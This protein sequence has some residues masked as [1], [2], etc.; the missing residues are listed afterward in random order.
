MP[1]ESLHKKKEG[2]EG[3]MGGKLK[4]IITNCLQDV[5]QTI[6]NW[7]KSFFVRKENF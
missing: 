1:S 4:G 5:A 3:E 7:S 2:D 6:L